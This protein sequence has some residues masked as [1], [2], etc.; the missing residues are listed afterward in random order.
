MGQKKISSPHV[1]GVALEASFYIGTQVCWPAWRTAATWPWPSFAFSS[2]SSGPSAVVS[3]SPCTVADRLEHPRPPPNPPGP[4]LPLTDPKTA[5]P[6]YGVSFW[7]RGG[8]GVRFDLDPNCLI[9]ILLIF[10]RIVIKLRC[11]CSGLLPLA[12]ILQLVVAPHFHKGQVQP[13]IT[14]QCSHCCH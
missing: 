8:E 2:A 11:A 10:F 5:K 4:H 7:R 3:A 9:L 13:H 12:V 14:L 1:R 6:R